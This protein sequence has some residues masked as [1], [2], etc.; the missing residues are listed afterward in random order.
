MEDPLLS[1]NLEVAETFADALIGQPGGIYLTEL[2]EL[3]K[4]GWGNNKLDTH[5]LKQREMADSPDAKLAKTWFQNMKVI[6]KELDLHAA[7]V[8]TSGQFTFLDLGFCPGGF[9]SY[10]LSRNA[11]ATGKGISLPVGQGGHAYLLE[12]HLRK[13]F[14]AHFGDLGFYN[15]FNEEFALYLHNVRLN[16]LPQSILNSTY[17]LVILDG[18]SLRNY[19]TPNHEP[20]PGRW[21]AQRLLL[22]QIIVS[23][24]SVASDGTIVIKLSHPEGYVTATILMHTKRGTFYAI[25][26]GVGI[27][28]NWLKKEN[29]LFRFRLLWYEISFGGANG[30]GRFLLDEG[31]KDLD[32]IA[33]YDQ[34]FVGYMERLAE[35]GED[36]WR[37]QGETLHKWFRQLGVL[38]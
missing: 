27:G 24:Q 5:F 6:F 21:E 1:P 8:P 31:A 16:N 35:L 33:S 10:I 4:V 19:V 32:F 37:I 25:A 9:T 3:R 11:D 2:R 26:K 23:L 18:H 15:L 34:L 36:V 17:D 13:R 12:K 14:K 7:I 30:Q 38:S 29:Y 28:D 22:S 20:P